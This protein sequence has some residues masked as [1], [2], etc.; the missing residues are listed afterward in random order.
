ML[1]I[2]NL[3]DKLLYCDDHSSLSSTSAVQYEFHIYLLSL[4]QKLNI[5]LKYI[6]YIYSSS[7]L[8]DLI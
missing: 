8:S 5:F 2:F 1:I 7:F 3:T 6:N 4:N